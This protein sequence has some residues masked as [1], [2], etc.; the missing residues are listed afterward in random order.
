MTG[1]VTHWNGYLDRGRK[2]LDKRLNQYNVVRIDRPRDYVYPEGVH[3]SHVLDG[4][5]VRDKSARH[6]HADDQHTVQQLAIRHLLFRE[7]IAQQHTAKHR[8]NTADYRAQR[9]NLERAA[10]TL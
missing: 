4:Q 2:L 10:Q 6:V 1:P 7:Q 9:R 3:K 8:H 5:V